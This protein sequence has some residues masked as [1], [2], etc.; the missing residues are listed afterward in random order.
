MLACPRFRNEREQLQVSWEGPLTPEGIGSC[1]LTSQK[2]WDVVT[3]LA[4]SIVE[5]LN[6]IR[7][8]EERGAWTA[9]TGEVAPG[10]AEE[11]L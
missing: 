11:G 5:R 8:A 10:G 7:R 2:G 6:S 3:T 4:T 1:L 9:L